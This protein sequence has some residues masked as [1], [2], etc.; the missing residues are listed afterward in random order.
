MRQIRNLPLYRPNG[1]PAYGWIQIPQ[2][3]LNGDSVTINGDVYNYGTDFVGLSAAQ[4]LRSLCEAINADQEEA[5]EVNPTNT[6]FFRT[7]YAEL[8]GS[9][10]V[11]FCTVPGTAG[12]SFTLATSNA[13]RIAVSGATFSGGT[14]GSIVAANGGALI[15]GSGTIAAGGTA[16]Q[17]IAA[18][19]GRVYLYV[20]N[21][22]A[23]ET[24]YVNF[25]AVATAGAG[26]IQL[27]P[28]GSQVYEADY[29]P[30]GL[31]SVIAATTGHQYTVKQA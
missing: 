12:N 23:A 7:Y 27:L 11:V 13:N 20:Q 25:G 3:P 30:S 14:S 28:G 10:I 21:L 31:V 1:T 22:D 15:D 17:A 5:N 18:L 16:Q 26:S 2:N 8:R 9:Y 19:L 6:N 24:L 4:A 29:I